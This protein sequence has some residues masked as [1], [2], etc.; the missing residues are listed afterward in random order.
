MDHSNNQPGGFA[1]GVRALTPEYQRRRCRGHVR[2]PPWPRPP[3]VPKRDQ[4]PLPPG[5]R[6]Y[7]RAAWPGGIG[8]GS[9]A[10]TGLVPSGRRREPPL[11]RW[12][13]R[14][15]GAE[16]PGQCPP[17]KTGASAGC[18]RR[19]WSRPRWSWSR[20]LPWPS[21]WAPIRM[22]S[23]RFTPP[24]PPC[25][26][27]TRPPPSRGRAV[28][29]G[30][31]RGQRDREPPCR[32]RPR[33]EPHPSLVAQSVN[34]GIRPAGDGVGHRFPE[35]GWGDRGSL[36]RPVRSDILSIPNLVP[37]DG[38]AAALVRR[39]PCRSPSPRMRAPR[40]P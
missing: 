33:R 29:H 37:G 28:R 13:R 20:P 22:S 25:L 19:C 38:A 23:P 15:K 5:R 32:A 3:V 4:P 24:A 1:V 26:Q 10:P 36:R 40:G 35:R 7:K 31:G 27:V 39:A 6:R 14:P 21:F 8:A 9:G 34:G 18:S 11:P 17:P 16:T 12:A 2:S 30:P